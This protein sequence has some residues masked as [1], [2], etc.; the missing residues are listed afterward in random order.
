MLGDVGQPQLVEVIAEERATD[1]IVADP[2]TGP[3]TAAS[4]F[5]WAE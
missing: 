3:A 1:Q 4:P 2:R 5:A